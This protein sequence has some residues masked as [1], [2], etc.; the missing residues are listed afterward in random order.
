MATAVALTCITFKPNAEAGVFI[1][2]MIAALALITVAYVQIE[3]LDAIKLEL[4][5]QTTLVVE[6]VLER[7]VIQDDEGNDSNHFLSR[8][9]RS[10]RQRI[11]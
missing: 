2:L 9:V 5:H 10:G 6:G 8:S 4:E 1:F 7:R 3:K 11:E